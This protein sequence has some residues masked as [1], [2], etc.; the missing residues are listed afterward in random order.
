MVKAFSLIELIFAIVIMGLAV[1]TLPRVTQSVLDSVGFSISQE[2]I[3][4]SSSAIFNILDYKWDENSTIAGSLDRKVVDVSNSSDG[5]HSDLNRSY[6]TDLNPPSYNYRDGHF[7]ADGRR[8][9]HNSVA[10]ASTPAQLG[11]NSDQDDI[12]DF[13]GSGINLAMLNLGKNLDYKNS[14]YE[15]NIDVYYIDDTDFTAIDAMGNTI[16]PS[17]YK[18]AV[19]ITFNLTKNPSSAST[20]IKFIELNVTDPQDTS[21][22]MLRL[23]A[24]SSNIGEYFDLTNKVR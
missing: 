9:F 11:T 3:W 12:D 21:R 22:N 16:T 7:R 1:S 4:L 20:N 14:R 17:N 10:Y 15:A 23:I 5:G 2:A 8:K 24:F 6:R 19:E 18:N 13:I